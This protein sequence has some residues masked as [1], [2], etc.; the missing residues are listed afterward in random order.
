MTD[1][2]NPAPGV[3][4]RQFTDELLGA[5]TA[6]D[7]DDVTEAVAVLARSGS[8]R[9]A[10]AVAGELVDR[11]RTAIG[12]RRGADAGAF[13]T[14]V[15][16]DAHGE[17]AEV[18]RLPP[19]PRSALRALLAALNDDGPSRD[20]H[21]ELAARGRPPDLVAVLTHLVVWYLEL[22]GPAAAVFPL[23]SCFSD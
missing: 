11:C 5:A 6:G 12:A 19:G 22:S 15:V 16:E 3:S 20:I 14:V 10:A 23:L 13:F 9:V 2:G 4:V 8:T 17:S 7:Y 21:V 1:N 18:E